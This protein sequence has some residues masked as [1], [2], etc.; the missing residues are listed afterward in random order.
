MR[1]KSTTS[2]SF[3]LKNVNE[4][5]KLYFGENF[6]ISYQIRD[7]ILDATSTK[8]ELGKDVGQDKKNRKATF[9][10]LYGVEKASSLMNDYAEKALDYLKPYGEK[11]QRLSDIVAFVMKSN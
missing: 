4:R 11:Y 7:D 3:G 8:E 1:K 10:S 9:V 2:T 6:G 5:I